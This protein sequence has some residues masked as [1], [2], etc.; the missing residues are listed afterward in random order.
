MEHV[1]DGQ[2]LAVEVVPEGVGRLAVV[3]QQLLDAHH[4]NLSAFHHQHFLLKGVSRVLQR[5]H[6]ES[7]VTIIVVDADDE[8]DHLLGGILSLGEVESNFE[9]LRS[10]GRAL[11]FDEV[12]NSRA[13]LLRLANH[14]GVLLNGLRSQARSPEHQERAAKRTQ[15]SLVG[16]VFTSLQFVCSIHF[17]TQKHNIQRPGKWSEELEKSLVEAAT[18]LVQVEV[19]RGLQ[20]VQPQHQER[21]TG[22]GEVEVVVI[23]C[24]K[25]ELLVHVREVDH[26]PDSVEAV[27]VRGLDLRNHELTLAANLLHQL[28]REE[29]F[30]AL[31]QL[32][33][34]WS[35]AVIV[36]FGPHVAILSVFLRKIVGGVAEHEVVGVGLALGSH[37]SSSVIAAGS[38][39]NGTG[40]IADPSEVV[41]N[42]VCQVDVKVLQVD[43]LRFVF[44]NLL[45]SHV[46]DH[47]VEVGH[48]LEVRW[49]LGEVGD[50]EG[51]VESGEIFDILRNALRHV[52]RRDF[53]QLAL[54]HHEDHGCHGM[55]QGLQEIEGGSR[56][57]FD[58]MLL[59][60]DIS[61]F[62]VET[63][64]D[65][66]SVALLLL[67][68]DFAIQNLSIIKDFI[69]DLLISIRFIQD[70]GDGPDGDFTRLD[71]G[72]ELL[73]VFIRRCT[74]HKYR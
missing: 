40:E 70:F 12:G 62:D 23:T 61:Q 20:R 48:E 14:G 52:L 5:V 7:S 13:I 4:R 43:K 66:D 71:L 57:K 59:N 41:G 46:E 69:L 19:E 74:F 72:I 65:G 67:D 26:L 58:L 35:I 30:K 68:L 51:P 47:G 27:G 32:V 10:R 49:I 63:L 50:S 2:G 6:S 15:S 24:I 39:H 56:C 8:E 25:I 55:Q 22:G 29:F 44:A 73:F 37:A 36:F 45:Q 1:D 53:S 28:K 18:G 3:D 16:H 9:V 33:G 34:G 42:H 38:E 21:G 54:E 17:C 31:Q 11:Q 60:L 64:L